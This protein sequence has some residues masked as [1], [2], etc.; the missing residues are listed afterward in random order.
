MIKKHKILNEPLSDF[1]IRGSDF[2]SLVTPSAQ[3]RTCLAQYSLIMSVEQEHEKRSR[4]P[5]RLTP[6]F[7][8]G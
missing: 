8:V 6:K 3:L 5:A 1:D 2:D 4:F 7:V